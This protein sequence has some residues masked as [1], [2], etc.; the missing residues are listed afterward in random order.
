MPMTAMPIAS[1]MASAAMSA[2]RTLPSV[3]NS[4]ST[5]KP[6]AFGQVDG[7]GVQ[8]AVD[9][10]GA[11]VVAADLDAGGQLLLDLGQPRLDRADHLARVGADQHHHG[12]GG[13][14]ALAVLGDD[15]EA[16]RRADLHRAD[17]LEQ[18]RRAVLVGGHHGVAD[19]V[20]ALELRVAAD[21]VGLAVLLDV[22]AAT[23]RVV[24]HRAPRARE[25]A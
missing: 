17:L 5:T 14:L 24:A 3:R 6:G 21:D 13:D 22:A 2:P 10:L 11:I 7:D 1:G 20:E 4:T 18:Y 15:A 23:R 16:Q 9:E 12:A 8:H 19:V 25:R